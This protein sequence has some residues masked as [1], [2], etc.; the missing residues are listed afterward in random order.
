[1]R[2]MI[3]PNGSCMREHGIT[4]SA[5]A[6]R[7]IAWRPFLAA[8]IALY[9]FQLAAQI[10]TTVA[11][12]GPGNNIPAVSAI[13]NNPNGVAVDGSGN[14]FFTDG[15]L[16]KKIDARTAMVST[17][18]GNGSSFQTLY[19]DNLPATSIGLGLA[20]DGTPNGLAVG[21]DGDLFIAEWRNGRVRRVSAATGFITNVAGNGER[22]F[23]G[24]GIAATSASLDLMGNNF[25]GAGIA[26]D[27]VGNLFIA[28]NGNRR[29]RRVDAATGL[30]STIA[31]TGANGPRIDNI[32]AR[33]AALDA[34]SAVAVDRAGNVF[35]LESGSRYLRKVAAGT[36]VITTV[37]G[38]GGYVGSVFG[39]P[40]NAT[41]GFTVGLA[42]DVNGDLYLADQGVGIRKISVTSGSISLV[43][44]GGLGGREG[45]N[46]DNIPATSAALNWPSA[47]ALDSSGNIYIGD[48][49][50]SRIRKVTAATSIISTIAGTGETYGLIGDNVAAT[51]ATLNRPTGI[52][53]D[54]LGQLFIADSANGKIRRVSP[55]S[56][57]ISSVDGGSFV[58][59]VAV[60]VDSSGNLY[61][62]D[63]ASSAVYKLNSATGIA[64][65]IAGDAPQGFNGDNIPA[66][67]A[68]LFR[69]T[70]I[71]IDS[72]GNVYIADR[73][74]NRVRKI[75]VSTGLISTVAGIGTSG[76][77]GDGGAAT[78]AQLS[79]PAGVA[80][81]AAGHLYIGDS[82]NG[83]LRKV[84]AGTGVITTVVSGLGGAVLS[85]G[86]S[87]S[88]NGP[89]GVS[90]DSSGNVYFA[91]VSQSYKWMPMTET[92]SSIAGGGINNV[93]NIPATNAS[94]SGPRSVVVDTSGNVFVAEEFANRI[95]KLANPNAVPP[96]TSYQGLWWNAP[97]NSESGWG[98]NFA[99]QGDTIFATWFTYGAD[100][101]AFW[102]TMVATATGNEFVGTIYQARGPAF[103]AVPFRPDA[104]SAVALGT[105]T[106]RFDDA[107][108]A[109]F[110]Y[111]IANVRQSRSLTK[112]V[113]GTL[114]TCLLV[115]QA[116]LSQ[117][118]NYQDIWW[119]APA[120][121]ESGWGVNFSH[122]GEALFATWFTYDTNGAPMW[123]SA[124]TRRTAPGVFSGPIYR[125]T[126]TPFNVM[127]FVSASLGVV[128]VGSLSIRFVDGN[129]AQFTYV[130]DGVSQSKPIT[131]QSFGSPPSACVQ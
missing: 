69:P 70:G 105:G 83:R 71:A 12:G 32:A 126:G 75:T 14:V 15:N 108:N 131:R 58:Q 87:T 79:S 119:G 80:I 85:P 47:V 72:S 20:L 64:A 62:A 56:G 57:K 94:L 48:T 111:T 37:A 122:Q 73:S 103:S 23:N 24:D 8:L 3:S 127:P 33:E 125:T 46:G 9:S 128:E 18:A 88:P 39:D 28:D 25:R 6:L 21:P 96:R 112:Q 29:V 30:I 61:V 11:G 31:G 5:D 107:S 74:N 116:I 43:A 81:D 45:F 98:I 41:L 109:E 44:G 2:R 118:T 19:G 60:T 106:L 36:G 102:M 10:I 82:G 40:L 49:R 13:L 121:F 4:R 130:L 16:V 77:S 120:G 123:V 35:V 76:F 55:G 54:T 65:V 99:H 26:F 110:T 129:E 100:R 95:R 93:D 91:A 113:F 1:M 27:S 52:A 59:P 97:A 50:N 42:I 89:S 7:F 38:N 86:G 117:S 67:T 34:P 78:T 66:V 90:V 115:P 22:G 53:V 114:P 84:A 63:Q 17:Y 92:L 124:S 101:K 51:R 68:A 104:V